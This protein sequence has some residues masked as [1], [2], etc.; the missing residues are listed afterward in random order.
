MTK[1]KEHIYLFEY[2]FLNIQLFCLVLTV[3]FVLLTVGIYKVFNFDFIPSIESVMESLFD[4]KFVLF[5]VVMMLWLVLH[6]IIHGI[7]YVLYGANFKNIKYGVVLEKGILYCKC[8]Q[9]IDKKNILWSVINPFIYI[10]VVTL[11]LGFAFE[12][13]W[14]VALSLI[15]IS[16]ACADILMFLFFVRRDKNMKFKEIKDSST[17]ILKTT[18]DLSNKKFFAVKL[19]QEL[20]DDEFKEKYKLITVSIFSKVFLIIMG[21]LLVVSLIL[22]FL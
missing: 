17:F 18:E 2:N 14:L 9:Y 12:S 7:S 15:N 11:L 1:K 21:I 6:E 8:G 3:L 4:S 10:G 20:T 19:N 16:G 5:M 13:L 22:S